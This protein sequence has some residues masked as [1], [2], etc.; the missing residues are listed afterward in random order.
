MFSGGV[1]YEC[2]ARGRFR[3]DEITP[4]VGDRVEFDLD[5]NDKGYLTAIDKR[6]NVLL[7]PPVANIDQFVLVLSASKP[8][9]DLLLAD[10]L[11][12]QSERQNVRALIVLNK[13][14]SAQTETLEQLKSEYVGLEYTFLMT[15]AKTEEGLAQLKNELYGKLSCFAGQ[16]AVGKSSILNA[17][18]ASFNLGVGDLGRT[19]RGRHTTRAIELLSLD[20]EGFVL[21]TPGFSLLYMEEI[22]P[23]QLQLYYPEMRNFSTKCRFQ[24]CLHAGEPDCT[25]KSELLGKRLSH[26]RYERYLLILEELKEMRKHKYD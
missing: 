21:D 4:L 15:S 22:L 6:T 2:H 13:C 26:G 20:G 8:I 19:G 3:L 23:E 18:C 10:K 25:V 17:M 11:L 14:D 12:I 1:I 5:K 9:P 24:N 7:R 16:S